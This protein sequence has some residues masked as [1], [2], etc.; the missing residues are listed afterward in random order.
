MGVSPTK[1]TPYL[2]RIDTRKGN[3]IASKIKSRET[4]F[5]ALE[6]G[7]KPTTK[8]STNNNRK[9]ELWI[10]PLKFDNGFKLNY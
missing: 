3:T 5:P 4:L 7:N 9:K 1:L 2:A 6:K 8:T 10:P